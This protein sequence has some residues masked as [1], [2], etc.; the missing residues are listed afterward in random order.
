MSYKE[1]QFD[2]YLDIPEEK[3]QMAYA[4]EVLG[5]KK[6]ETKPKGFL[7][8]ALEGSAETVPRWSVSSLFSSW[9]FTPS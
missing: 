1:N 6:L 2:A 3:F 7:R 4:D 5:E 9:R 8:D